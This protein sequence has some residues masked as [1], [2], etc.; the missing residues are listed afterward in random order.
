MQKRTKC[1][2]YTQFVY[3]TIYKVRYI[4]FCMLKP[5]GHFSASRGPPVGNHV[6]IP[7]AWNKNTRSAIYWHY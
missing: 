3:A 2:H 7:Q 5:H 4:Y 1:I 6:D